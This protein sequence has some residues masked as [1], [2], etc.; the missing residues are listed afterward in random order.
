VVVAVVLGGGGSPNPSTEVIL[1]FAFAAAALAWLWLPVDTTGKAF[2]ADRLV[3]VLMALVLIVPVVQLVPLPPSIWTALPGRSN[4]LAALSLVGEQQSWRPIALSPSRTLASLLATLPP[5]FCLYAVS[6]LALNDRRLILGAIVLMA[7]VTSLI[8]VFQLTDQGQGLNLYRDHSAGWV[9]GFQANRNAAADLLLIGIIALAVIVA[10]YVGPERQ[11]KPMQLDRRTFTI[12]S[13]GVAFLLLVATVMTGSRAGTTLILVAAAAAVAVLLL[14]RQQSAGASSWRPVLVAIVVVALLGLVFALLARFTALGQV[15]AR[16]A[17]KESRTEIWKDAWFALKQYWPTGFGMGGF[18]PAILP[19]ERLEVL[20]PQI[21]NRA[22]NDYLEIGLEAGVLGVAMVVMAAV[23]CLSMLWR[24]WR[25]APAQ[26]QQVIFGTGALLVI[27]LH[28][29]VDY[30]GVGE[31]ELSRSAPAAR[32]VTAGGRSFRRAHLE[33]KRPAAAG[34]SVA[35][36]ARH[37]PDDH[38]RWSPQG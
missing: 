10:P 19:A 33:R 16:F 14:A 2:S 35:P 13:A 1:E 27:A 21:P 18:E 12:L 31:A 7:V 34:G 4:E 22:H 37:L 15:S 6:R 25:R 5:L 30:P 36:V 3:L 9:Q 23:V 29:V 26:R 28:S 38:R 24:S 32:R 17:E 8:G 20:G 11:R